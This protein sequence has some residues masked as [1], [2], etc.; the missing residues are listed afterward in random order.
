MVVK[1]SADKGNS[2]PLIIRSDILVES[3]ISAI[4]L[5]PLLTIINLL[6]TSHI[7]NSL[8]CF[9]VFAV[10]F[11]TSVTVFGSLAKRQ[12]V[13]VCVLCVCVVTY[14]N[15]MKHNIIYSRCCIIKYKIFQ[16]KKGLGIDLCN[17]KYGYKKAFRL[18]WENVSK[19][20]PYFCQNL[21]LANLIMTKVWIKFWYAISSQPEYFLV[22]ILFAAEINPYSFFKFK[23][24]FY[25]TLV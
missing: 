23:F 13:C 18:A 12:N 25:S 9:Q 5:S 10:P 17:K 4:T 21:W 6:W 14:V 7:W 3:W 15:L 1:A 11:R 22:S 8:Y 20:N 24:C 19:F 16:S 2:V